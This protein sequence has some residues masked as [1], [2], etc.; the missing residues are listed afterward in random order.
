M[1]LR[2]STRLSQDAIYNLTE[3]A[4]EST[5][6][7]RI[8]LYPDLEVIVMD[9]EAIDKICS[10]HRS[11]QTRQQVNKKIVNK[12]AINLFYIMHDSTLK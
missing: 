4:D 2:N 7:R 6:I 1:D 8:A 3:I 12:L 5:F 10:S 11:P 9:Q